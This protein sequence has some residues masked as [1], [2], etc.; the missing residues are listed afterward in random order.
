M[1]FSTLDEQLVRTYATSNQDVLKLV[2]NVHA[3]QSS[4]EENFFGDSFSV[5]MFLEFVKNLSTVLG[6]VVA[7][8]KIVENATSLFKWA[9]KR[10][11]Q[12][13]GIQSESAPLSERALVL[14]FEAYVNRKAG[15][16][17]ERLA[18]LLGLPVDKVSGM[19][20]TLAARGVA[21][22]AR[23]GKWKYVRSN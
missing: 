16:D 5:S 21:R 4:V 6:G 22:R 11:T 17:E 3:E 2:I 13:G 9:H 10:L 12:D 20:E 7:V 14:L 8:T 19:L 23:D 15:L 18:M 1:N